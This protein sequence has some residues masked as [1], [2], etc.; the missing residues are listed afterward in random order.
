[1]VGVAFQNRSVRRHGIKFEPVEA[2]TESR[3]GPSTPV[4]AAID[5]DEI[6]S[7]LRSNAH[8]QGSRRVGATSPV[9]LGEALQHSLHR[10]MGSEDGRT[11]QGRQWLQ[12]LRP[13]NGLRLIG[14]SNPEARIRHQ[15][16][17]RSSY[18]STIQ[19]FSSSS[20]RRLGAGWRDHASIGQEEYEQAE[21]GYL[22]HTGP[23][24]ASY[25]ISGWPFGSSAALGLKALAWGSHFDRNSHSLR[26]SFQANT[27]PFGSHL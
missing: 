22:R 25:S 12:V 3:R 9:F 10:G 1:M 5:P 20:V 18:R 27:L 14:R 16:D 6:Q 11:I 17:R 4:Q 15:V 23:G 2:G 8:L 21:I 19:G 7:S 13:L 24:F 26:A